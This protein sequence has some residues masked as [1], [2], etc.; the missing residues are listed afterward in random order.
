MEKSFRSETV[1]ID[2][3]GFTDAFH[4]PSN[5]KHLPKRS[6]SARVQLTTG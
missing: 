3:F 1:D 4:P 2:L 6:S 5:R